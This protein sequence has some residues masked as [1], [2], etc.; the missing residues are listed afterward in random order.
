MRHSS[1]LVDPMHTHSGFG[2]VEVE[3]LDRA[4]VLHVYIRMVSSCL[5]GINGSVM[6]LL[7]CACVTALVLQCRCGYKVMW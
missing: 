4:C 2:H 5:H 6:V 7:L 1:H 3:G